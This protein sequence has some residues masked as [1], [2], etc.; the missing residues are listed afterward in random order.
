MTRAA[1]L[2]RI[3]PD[4]VALAAPGAPRAAR[5]RAAPSAPHRLVTEG[6]AVASR[7]RRLGSGGGRRGRERIARAPEA[8]RPRPAA[9]LGEA[10][11]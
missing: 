3:L 9:L 1:A 2:A 4:A 11:R 5:E 8:L 6:I 7:A 10:R